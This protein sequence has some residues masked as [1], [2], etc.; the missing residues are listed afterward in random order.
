MFVG[1]VQH[2]FTHFV[3]KLGKSLERFFLKVNKN[4]FLTYL[5]QLVHAKTFYKKT[6]VTI[7]PL[8]IPNFTPNFK[9]FLGAVS[10]IIRSARMQA[11]MHRNYF[12][13]LFKL[14]TN[15]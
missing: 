14:G 11:R 9:K 10:D 13:G 5:I 1:W 3:K 2:Y 4:Y 12:I 6:A 7:E 8:W 15:H